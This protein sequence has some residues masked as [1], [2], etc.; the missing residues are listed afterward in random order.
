MSYDFA[1]ADRT[2]PP[3]RAEG[4]LPPTSSSRTARLR[5]PSALS[6]FAAAHADPVLVLHKGQGAVALDALVMLQKN[7]V[8]KPPHAGE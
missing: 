5:C 1:F 4:S 7:G 8:G 2:E 6:R 3:F